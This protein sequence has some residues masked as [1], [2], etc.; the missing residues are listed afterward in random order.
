MKKIL[1]VSLALVLTACGVVQPVQQVPPTPVIATVLVTVIPPTE[2]APPTAIPL[3]TQAP[4]L[5]PTEVPTQVPPT[6]T[7]VPPTEAVQ[8]TVTQA[9]A[10]QPTQGSTGPNTSPVAFDP[11]FGG[12]A[13]TNMTASTGIFY[14][15]CAPKDIKF[16]VTTTNVYITTVEMYF[17]IRDKHSTYVPEWTWGGTLETDGGYH[18]WITINSER[19]NPDLRKQQG[20]YDVEFVGLNKLGDVVGRTEKITDVIS[21]A[22]DC[23]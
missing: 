13:F 15:R 22:V 20:W 17:R 11:S 1:L 5:P 6:P 12:G 2:A 8:P 3:P 23:K 16:D 21:F 18:F 10:A 14:L 19:V 7:A 4:T 9:A